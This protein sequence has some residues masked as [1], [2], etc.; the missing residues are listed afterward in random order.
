MSRS[1]SLT[2]AAMVVNSLPAFQAA[3]LLSKLDVSDVKSVL[4]VANDLDQASANELTQCLNRLRDDIEHTKQRLDRRLSGMPLGISRSSQTQRPFEFLSEAIPVLR[5]HVLSDEH[6]RNIAIVLSLF[7]PD[8]ASTTMAGLEPNLR[9]SVLKR[10]C[11]LDEIHDDDVTELVY[12][13]RMRYNRLLHSKAGRSAG[14]NSAVN[15]LSCSDEATREMLLTHVGQSDPD[16][17]ETLKRSIFG[18]ERLCSFTDSD[19]KI[20]LRNV[21][22]SCWAPALKNASAE[23]I[24]KILSNMGDAPRGLLSHEIAE[25]GHVDSA[26]E[27]IARKAIV[28]AVLG[29]AREGK[30]NVKSKVRAPHIAFPGASQRSVPM[31]PG[32]NSS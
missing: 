4:K 1:S 3:Q 5:H 15:L 16:L 29:L 14:I 22:T 9:I 27:D 12:D 10:M 17:A 11:E 28:K 25:I 19:I 18:V 21:D 7:S 24:D 2:Q 8:V 20:V 30:V 31:N 26:Q 13:L 6:P 32:L 23:L